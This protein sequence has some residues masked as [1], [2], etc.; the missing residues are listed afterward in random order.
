M[1]I[2]EQIKTEINKRYTEY[3]EKQK[4]DDLIYYEGM[5]DALDLF[6]QFIDTLESEKPMDQEGLEEE[7]KDY[8]ESDPVYSKLVNRN[9]GLSIA[10]HFAEWGAEH[11]ANARKT[12]SNDLEEAAEQATI[13]E[14]ILA[15]PNFD[16]AVRTFKAGV[17][18]RDSHF[19]KLPDDLDK[20]ARKAAVAPFNFDLDEEHLY[21]YPY[22]PIAE[23]KFKEG[24]KWQKQEMLKEAVEGTVM[25]FSS[26]QPRPQ[27]D[28]YVD[29]N[30]YCTGDKV[31]II[32]VKDK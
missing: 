2:I 32:I 17:K 26:N 15:G 12:L 7:Y 20:A 18:W 5:A 11:L 22:L 24:A 30:K 31:R 27:V 4:T 14:G 3:S 21:E 1:T 29:P 9:A 8:V 13:K 6:E 25:D 16:V 19:P 10:S 23:Q 28:V